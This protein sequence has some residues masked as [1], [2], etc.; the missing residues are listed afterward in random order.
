MNLLILIA[1]LVFMISGNEKS[2]EVIPP[3]ALFL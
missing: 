3:D 1:S 2:K